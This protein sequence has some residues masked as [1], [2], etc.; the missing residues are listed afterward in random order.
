MQALQRGTNVTRNTTQR[1]VAD[2]LCEIMPIQ[3]QGVLGP[4]Y[5]DCTEN[6]GVESVKQI[7]KPFSLPDEFTQEKLLKLWMHFLSS[8]HDREIYCQRRQ[9]NQVYRFKTG[10]LA[11]QA[12]SLAGRRAGAGALAGGW[13]ASGRR[14]GSTPQVQ[15]FKLGQRTRNCVWL[16]P[17]LIPRAWIGAQGLGFGPDP[18][19]TQ[20]HTL[21]VPSFLAIV[22]LNEAY[23][24]CGVQS[25]VHLRVVL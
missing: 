5:Q 16:T 12:D 19:P 4:H 22:D 18:F 13:R 20:W 9:V 11:V 3:V 17:D 2:W 25:T 14:V 10:R 24:L 23:T 1:R 8:E 15:L 21:H 7:N 6:Q